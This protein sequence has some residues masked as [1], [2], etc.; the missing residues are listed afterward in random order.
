[1]TATQP[2]RSGGRRFN[3]WYVAYAL[4]V[5]ALVTGAL[6]AARPG[7]GGV[8]EAPSASPTLSEAPSV[9]AGLPTFEAS[10]NAEAPQ[11]PLPG[12]D[13]VL[14]VASRVQVLADGLRLREFPRLDGAV[15]TR[16]AAG[17]VVYV[18]D[19][20]GTQLPPTFD[21]GYA[22]YPVQFIPGYADWPADPPT[23]T[24]AFGY[25]AGHST[26]GELLVELMEPRCPSSADIESLTRITAWERASCMGDQQLTLE[27]TYGCGVCD[28]LVYEGTWEPEWLA[29]YL[30]PMSPLSPVGQV[31]ELGVEPIV[32]AF[33]PAVGKPDSGMSGSM[34]RMIGHFNDRLSADCVVGDE[35]GLSE[36]SA[37]EWYC[38][39]RFVVDQWEV[40]GADPDYPALE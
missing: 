8:S 26:E 21:D 19:T 38:R 9:S 20:G 40:T 10:P 33:P 24:A 18:V 3:Y 31:Q 25:V 22:W 4:A 30:N 5:I 2:V 32:L 35:S 23:D 36:D 34:M 39:E 17:E 16:I 27:G 28:S 12:P 29:S 1:M 13:D 6:L 14:P 15:L 37:A 7:Q 11:T